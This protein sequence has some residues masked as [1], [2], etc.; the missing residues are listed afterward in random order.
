MERTFISYARDDD[1]PFV[2]R[3]YRDLMA[4]DLFVWWDRKA[5][6]SRGRTF[7]DEIRDAITS[8][9][10]IVLVVG[11][12][13]ATSCYV[14]QEWE[15]ALEACKV[16][17]PILRLGSSEASSNEDYQL[18]PAPLAGL[19]C[20]DFRR[21]RRY[22]EALDELAGILS[23]PLSRPGDLYGVDTLPPH[24][25]ARP[26]LLKRLNE[27]VL[28]DSSQ[29][30]V[31]TS[32]RNATALEGMG[33][34]GKSVL[35]SAFARACG[36]R[37]RFNDGLIW[38]RFGRQPAVMS[39]LAF[40]GHAL[41]DDLE[42]Y[43]D[44]ETGSASLS[45]VLANRNCL[46][47]LD[48]IWDLVDAEPFLKPLG[49]GCRALITTRDFGLAAALGAQEQALDIMTDDQALNLL[50]QWS[51][52]LVPQLPV[53]ARRVVTECGNLPLALAMIGAMVKD[54]PAS[55]WADALRLLQDA[56]LERIH[57]KFP[58]YPYPDLLRAIEVSVTALEPEHAQRRYLDFAV[59]A[60]DTPVPE[61]VIEVF[62]QPL[63]LNE[64]ATH[65]FIDLF[66][67]R[68]LMR[69]D[70]SGRL[71]LHDL[72]HDFVRKQCSDLPTL[73]NRLLEAYQS[74][75]TTGWHTGPN[76]GYFFGH[77][78]HHL[79]EAGR[80]GEVHR[81][82]AA[83]T[84]EL[85]NGWY[86]AKEAIGAASGYRID[87]A[88]AWQLAERG[89]QQSGGQQEPLGTTI[90]LECRYALVSASL[91][92]VA[93]SVP[94]PMVVALVRNSIWTPDHALAYAL[95]IAE[96]KL[97]AEALAALAVHL[98][99]PL[100][101]LALGATSK[102]RALAALCP[103]LA[104]LGHP[105][106]ALALMA[107][108]PAE[109]FD[110][111]EEFFREAAKLVPRAAE[112]GYPEQA[113]A[114]VPK[115]H[116]FERG[117]IWP[118]LA[119]HLPKPLLPKALAVAVEG[120]EEFGSDQALTALAPYLAKSLLPDALDAAL[121]IGNTM[122]RV[123]ALRGLAPY[124]PN[125]LL[126]R[127]LAHARQIDDSLNRARALV[128]LA[129]RL[130]KSSRR[131]PLSEALA[132]VRQIEHHAFRAGELATL[133]PHLTRDLR[134]KVFKEALD[135]TQQA[136]E[137]H[138]K[139]Q[140][141]IDLVPHLP[142][143]LLRDALLVTQGITSQV[144]RAKT[145]TGLVPHLH[146]PLK[147]EALETALALARELPKIDDRVLALIDILPLL[148]GTRRQVVLDEVLAAAL[149]VEEAREPAHTL[150]VL[151]P[152]LPE[153]MLRQ[154][155][156]AMPRIHSFFDQAKV[157]ASLR[158]FLTEPLWAEALAAA[159]LVRP[160][161]ERARVL[162]EL[163][164]QMSGSWQI[165]AVRDALSAASE[166]PVEGI[167]LSHK[168]AEVMASVATHLPAAFV[169]EALALMRQISDEPHRAEA[170]AALAP[171][172]SER[173]LKIAL[174]AVL[175]IP[176]PFAPRQA[177]MLG[178]IA[179]RFAELGLPDRALGAIRAM[180]KGV[181][182][183]GPLRTL[184]SRLADLGCYSQALAA[185]REIDFGSHREE[186]LTRLIPLL[187]E[188]LVP[189]ALVIAR[190]VEPDYVRYLA[191]CALFP[192]L[193]ERLKREAFQELLG[194]AKSIGPYSRLRMFTEL[195][196]HLSE[197]ELREAI[198]L[199]READGMPG[200]AETAPEL[201]RYLP[202]PD[203]SEILREFLAASKELPETHISSGGHPRAEALI[204]LV[205]LLSGTLQQ[206]AMAA[207]LVAARQI[208]DPSRRA[209]ALGRLAGVLDEPRKSG[210]LAEALEAAANIS[211]SS[212]QVESLRALAPALTEPLL[213]RALHVARGIQ[214]ARH[215][216]NALTALAVRL[217]EPVRAESIG[218]AWAAAASGRA[219]T[220]AFHELAG[221]LLEPRRTAA[222]REAMAEARAQ[223]RAHKELA[224][225]AGY[226]PPPL[227]AE[228]MRDA[229]EAALKI[230]YIGDRVSA[231]G[232][233]APH[234]A[235]VPLEH[236]LP[237]W[238]KTLHGMAEKSRQDQLAYLQHLGPVILALGGQ[239]AIE[240]TFQAILDV[241]RWWP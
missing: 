176:E 59:F 22:R 71:S 89:G 68:S 110:R 82:L 137:S 184:A 73:H 29:P 125:P 237:I 26:E 97:R 34:I 154:V 52:Q 62:W 72:Q 145:L 126:K 167:F 227:M 9:D 189:E 160:N 2:K 196:P 140:S 143:S 198:A 80:G 106:E 232:E 209:A 88:Q 204:R 161:D 236:L 67:D 138:E 183:D 116:R 179:L 201:A 95:R 195:A 213:R 127:A 43:S 92:S 216:M 141:L 94:P 47:I 181:Y 222:L 175:R 199:V 149:R 156:E 164:S 103:R 74:C 118:A 1:E 25:L 178:S 53:E 55:R 235:G 58:N 240:E 46:L 185:I 211:D 111:L 182:R 21:S 117:R 42:N 224:E 18:I 202:D 6:E 132:A 215:R 120:I 225:L 129:V 39:N 24:Y 23:K 79:I 50:A 114:A 37:R 70:P 61:A 192:R 84:A 174:D 100:V 83:E 63:G 91:N 197:S 200:A 33:G 90:G 223:Y 219:R 44:L 233:L 7:L 238:R 113:L 57:R 86:E 4:R 124:L 150:G 214:D 109:P 77:M 212:K 38:L 166:T 45:R 65:Q 147:K 121:R 49:L 11:P 56:D 226:L 30:L 168:R 144:E 188:P 98:S 220:E 28:P 19:H 14:K 108:P 151:I 85:R 210:T 173:L 157:L 148:S 31:I 191:L 193:P 101:R 170:L 102:G 171:Y 27:M 186:S 54:K 66:V 15:F 206:E 105:V 64:A 48:D 172:V 76:D 177:E 5:M 123:S 12:G 122:D 228:V 20:P 229:L 135:A 40:A 78:L 112:L 115:L 10:R 81:L 163:A 16:I 153:I 139:R 17:V 146:A 96:P 165:E 13:A 51:G 3:L 75:C 136:G 241:G 69:R 159:R 221:Q 93:G 208:A 128:A 158:P 133:A 230:D 87:V 104:E 231:L 205:S 8:V 234:L 36:T 180:W 207:A 217:P 187:P 190:G 203:R 239:R 134:D 194:L 35:A 169:R 162:A 41:N 32:T 119:S 130:P 218:E 152:H 142:G 107:K 131:G 60:D 155:L 99:E